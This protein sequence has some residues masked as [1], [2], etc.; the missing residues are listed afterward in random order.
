MKIMIAYERSGKVREVFRKRGF[1]ATSCDILPSDLPGQ[2]IRSRFEDVDLAGY[3]VLIAFPPC[4]YLT[5][6]ANSYYRGNPKR[7]RKRSL[8]VET[9]SKLFAAPVRHI[10]I[11]NPV[12]VLSTRFR[13]PSQIIHPWQFGHREK[14]RTCLWLRRLPKLQPVRVIDESERI[15]FVEAVPGSSSQQR[16][17]NTT[18]SG[19]AEAM[20]EQWGD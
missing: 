10:A 9:V 17:R 14:K 19:I 1:D 4:T 13:P 7:E 11:E 8:A 6:A 3:D 18:F 12:G 2:H 5:I 20:A 16:I 15:I